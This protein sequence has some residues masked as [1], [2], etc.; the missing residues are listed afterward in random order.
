MVSDYFITSWIWLIATF[1]WYVTAHCGKVYHAECL[2]AWPQTSWTAG[3]KRGSLIKADVMT[4]PQHS[5]HT[6]VSDNPAVMKARFQNDKL[7]R[8]VRCPTSY[9]YGKLVVSCHFWWN[10]LYTNIYS[11]LI[12]LNKICIL[13]CFQV[14]YNKISQD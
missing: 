8:C 12:F 3:A 2:K 4:C 14:V 5:C 10:L 11:T 9:H 1:C 7:V 6:C 13:T